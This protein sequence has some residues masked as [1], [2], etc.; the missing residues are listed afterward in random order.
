MGRGWERGEKRRREAQESRSLA[1]VSDGCL[2]IV[3]PTREVDKELKNE[4]RGEGFVQ[5]PLSC[6]LWQQ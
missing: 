3:M 6:W 5:S 1:D 2:E 4:R